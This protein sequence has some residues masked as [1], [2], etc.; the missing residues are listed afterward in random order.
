MKLLELYID[1]FNC[2]ASEAPVRSL[3]KFDHHTLIYVYKG[4]MEIITDGKQFV[5]KKGKCAFI[6][7]GQM[8]QLTA[9]PA[10]DGEL[11]AVILY[12]P[13]C[14]LCEFFPTLHGIKKY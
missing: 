11:R 5:L 3:H 9:S 8:T 10:D 4:V 13:L 1:I 12:I 7:S 6:A 2:I 14:F